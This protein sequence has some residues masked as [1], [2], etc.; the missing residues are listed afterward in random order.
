LKKILVIILIN[1]IVIV[2][3]AC[4][5][6]KNNQ[7]SKFQTTVDANVTRDIFGGAIDSVT[8]II[9]Q[10]INPLSTPSSDP[11]TILGFYTRSGYVLQPI[12]KIATINSSKTLYTDSRLSIL[13]AF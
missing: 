4:F 3:G 2:A 12:D 7:Y 13:D 6:N 8:N 11:I 9:N 5:L 10:Y 1:F